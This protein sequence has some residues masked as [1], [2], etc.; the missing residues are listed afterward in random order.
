MLTLRRIVEGFAVTGALNSELMAE[1]A[2]SGFKT[3]LNFRPD[4][5]AEGQVT[6]AQ[7][8][9]LAAAAGLDYAHIPASKLELFDDAVVDAAAAALVRREG[10]LLATCASGQRA[11]IVWGAVQARAL[12]VDTVLGVFA[13]AGFD[14]DCLR[15]EFE[16]QAAR[17]MA[18]AERA[19]A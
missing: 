4:G 18:D 10:P 9:E 14:F 12:S 8:A 19:A 7:L 15:D 2:A 6:S 17:G 13:A 3:I 1:A 11:A 5:E 16:E